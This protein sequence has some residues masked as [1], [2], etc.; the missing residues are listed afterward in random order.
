MS[1]ERRKVRQMKIT[2]AGM[3]IGQRLGGLDSREAVEHVRIAALS[4]I[5]ECRAVWQFLKD[6]GLAT[7]AN[8]QDSLDRGYDSVLAQVQDRASEIMVYDGK[9]S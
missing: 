7:E 6:K 4:A 1:D 8:Y 5:A 3:A 2:M 9:P